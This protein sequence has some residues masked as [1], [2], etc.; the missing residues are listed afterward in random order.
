[1]KKYIPLFSLLI[2]IFTGLQYRNYLDVYR[3]N[4]MLTEKK[5]EYKELVTNINKYI[6]YENSYNLVS[7]EGKKLEDKLKELEKNIDIKNN[8]I[9][10]YKRKINTLNSVLK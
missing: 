10:D 6:E 1:M 3:D 2:A 4:K 7:S 9:N 5:K 8:R